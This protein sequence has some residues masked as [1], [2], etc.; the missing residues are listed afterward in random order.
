MNLTDE[1]SQQAIGAGINS[2]EF[3]VYSAL[4]L[5]AAKTGEVMGHAIAGE[6]GASLGKLTGATL[7]LTAST[8][9]IMRSKAIRDANQRFKDEIRFVSSPVPRGH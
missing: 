1:E 8:L 2:K 9:A 4:T 3:V 5:A 7:G 6:T